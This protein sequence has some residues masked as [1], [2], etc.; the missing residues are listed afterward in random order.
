PVEVGSHLHCT[1]YSQ[2]LLAL[3][4]VPFVCRTDARTDRS[5]LNP[6]GEEYPDEGNGPC[7]RAAPDPLHVT[8]SAA[9]HERYG[10]TRRVRRS[11]SP[12]RVAL[13]LFG[14]ARTSAT[15]PPCDPGR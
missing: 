4:L 2:V 6:G 7:C 14:S 13:S 1:C 11:P 10:R 9:Y 3:K 8:W 15:R 5:L 12:A